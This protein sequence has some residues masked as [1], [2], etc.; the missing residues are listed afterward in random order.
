MNWKTY[1]KK[2][3]NMIVSIVKKELV[4]FFMKDVSEARIGVSLEEAKEFTTDQP[5]TQF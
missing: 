1:S 2:P 3:H 5:G 4:N